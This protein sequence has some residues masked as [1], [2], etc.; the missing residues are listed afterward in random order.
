[1]RKKFIRNIRETQI[2][3]PLGGIKHR[4]NNVFSDSAKLAFVF[5]ALAG[6]GGTCL[7][8]YKKEKKKTDTDQ[9]IRMDDN[10]AKN[11]ISV[12][13]AQTANTINILQTRSDIKI[14]EHEKLAAIHKNHN[15]LEADTNPFP[16]HAWINDFD[17]RFTMPDYSNIFVLNEIL[18]NCP[19]GS[20][21]AMLFFLLSSFGAIC[22]SKVRSKYLDE[23]MH[24]PNIM[25]AVEGDS[26]AGKGD[27]K[28]MYDCLF[29]EII[30]SD[31][32]KLN[33]EDEH[34]IIQ[35]AGINVTA[36]KFF[37]IMK[38]N[39]EVH[40]YAMETEIAKVLEAFSKKGGINP[41][42]LRN[43]FDNDEIYYNSRAKDVAKGCAPV[44]MN[45]FFTGTP[46]AVDKLF[47]EEEVEGGTARRF[48]FT[49]IPE[50][51][52][53]S[54]T[55]VELPKAA[56]IEAIKMQIHNWRSSYCYCT[57]E[58]G[59][60]VPCNEYE[61]DLDYIKTALKQWISDQFI[62]SANDKIKERR[63]FAKSFASTAFNCAIVLHM[64]A[65]EPTSSQRKERK[66]VKE[67][68]LYIANY[69]TERFLAKFAK[70]VASSDN[71][72]DFSIEE[73]QPKQRHKLTYDEV[74]LWYYLRGTP[75]ENGNPMGYGTI[76][77]K[78]GVTI[79][80]VKNA[81]KKYKRGK[82][83]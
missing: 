63:Q 4:G 14:A 68:T 7:Y 20:K 61:I 28:K 6:I 49:P 47:T 51:K 18:D 34:Q 75:D 73:Q 83:W 3:T 41:S 46:K 10:K 82:V 56:I 53:A 43:A 11:T 79:D 78:L 2:S 59:N 13:N 9:D 32:K 38:H 40:V 80:D 24:A 1:M 62:L 35:T 27:Y 50:V 69:V 15:N 23:K 71:D 45:C 25:V 67:L 54:G 31:R 65:G 76:A 16:L 22:F 29:K 44:Y 70:P 52:A 64:M 37:D 57:N 55:N 66:A 5:I 39:Q 72:F 19:E 33:E 48:C 42:Y 60:D 77:K 58:I 21:A 12:N 30:Q 17:S 8:L 26:G 74:E 36:A 81:F